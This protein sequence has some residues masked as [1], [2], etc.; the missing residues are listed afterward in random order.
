MKIFLIGALGYPLLEIAWRGRTHPSMALAGGLGA[1]LIHGIN[2][3]KHALPT[4]ILLCGAGITA[5]EAACGLVWNRRHQ[6]WDYR[7]MPLN[8]SGQICLPFSLAW[9]GLSAAYLLL[10]QASW[11]TARQPEQPAPP[12]VP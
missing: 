6:V 10:S 12:P 2:Q 4:K 8:W 7:H 11:P 5:I 3:T 9:C 1:V